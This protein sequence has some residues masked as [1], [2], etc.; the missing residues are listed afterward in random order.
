MS[1]PREGNARV[2]GGGP[3]AKL[4]EPLPNGAALSSQERA[5]V[6]CG[7]PPLSFSPRRVGQPEDS[8]AQQQ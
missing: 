3:Y 7:S 8:G 1:P 5:D 4:E 2:D 6:H